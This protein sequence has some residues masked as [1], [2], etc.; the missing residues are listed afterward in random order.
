MNQEII[1]LIKIILI[2]LVLSADNA[3]VIGMTASQF[4]DQI[5]KKVLIYGTIAAVICRISNVRWCCKSNFQA[6]ITFLPLLAS[7]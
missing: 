3:I 7:H 4:N 2:D 6:Q 5:R 1:I